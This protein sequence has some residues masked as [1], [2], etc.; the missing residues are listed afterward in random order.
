MSLLDKA[1][2]TGIVP[3]VVI[4]DVKDAVPTAKALL[5]GGID[6]MEITFRTDA[7]A[8]SIRQV[9]EQVPEMIVGAGTVVNMKQCLAAEEAG[10]KFIVSPGFN[11]EVVG[12]C[13]EKGLDI[14]PGVAT[15][16]EI[17][18]GLEFGLKVLK[19]FPA[20]IYGGISALKAISGPFPDVSFIPTGGVGADNLADFAGLRNVC[21][22][23]GSWIC[24]AKDISE[25]NFGVITEL[26]REAGRKWK[27][28]TGQ[29]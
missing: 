8:E 28:A 3:V 22:V 18:M 9:A 13:V 21:A 16:T 7:A 11:K 2:K 1:R 17:M 15:P 20:K 4:K 12:Y 5:E 29:N 24:T 6:F 27:A 10:A 23:G 19:F 14:F 26:S 25:G